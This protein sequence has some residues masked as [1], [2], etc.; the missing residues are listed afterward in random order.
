MRPYS[1]NINCLRAFTF[2]N[3]LNTTKPSSIKRHAKMKSHKMKKL[4]NLN[5]I[6]V[7]T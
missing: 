4:K 2:S 7:L 5:N 3:M 6:F 1:C